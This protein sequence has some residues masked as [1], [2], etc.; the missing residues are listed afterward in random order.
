MQSIFCS[1]VVGGLHFAQRNV[2]FT[3]RTVAVSQLQ[4]LLL[5]LRP[6]LLASLGQSGPSHQHEQYQQ[7]QQHGEQVQV[8]VR[9]ERGPQLRVDDHLVLLEASPAEDEAQ[10]GE[11]QGDGDLGVGAGLGRHVVEPL[12]QVDV[13]PHAVAQLVHV[14]QVEHGLRV[15]LL[16]GGDPVVEGRG[17][18]VSVGAPTVVVV[19]A[20][21]DAG[22]GVAL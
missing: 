3:S 11:G 8:P 16:V 7:P 2:W 12:R 21:A 5:L 1:A 18:E 4:S 22:C 20:E 15:V 9:L 14:A 19:V 10:L 13:L 6:L 17:L